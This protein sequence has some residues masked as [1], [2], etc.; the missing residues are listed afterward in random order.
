MEGGT[1]VPKMGQGVLG[2]GGASF[3]FLI[4]PKKIAF[5][6]RRPSKLGDEKGKGGRKGMSK[7]I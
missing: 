2:D 7:I 5:T 6:Y 1:N 3:N 4:L